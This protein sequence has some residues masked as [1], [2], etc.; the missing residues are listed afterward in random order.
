[1]VGTDADADA[2]ADSST[3]GDQHAVDFV[4]TD[5]NPHRAAWADAALRSPHLHYVSRPVDASAA[6]AGLLGDVTVSPRAAPDAATRLKQRGTFRLFFLAFH[7]MPDH[8]AR[9][10]LKDALAS[11]DGFGIF[12]LQGRTARRVHHDLS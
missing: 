9:D 8:L 7:H 3:G 10:I 1:M 6:G 4:L 11:S 2:D 5:I 12:E